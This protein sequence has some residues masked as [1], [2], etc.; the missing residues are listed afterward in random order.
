MSDTFRRADTFLLQQARLL[1][2]RLFAATW[3]GAPRAAVVAALAAYQ[4][5]DGGFGHALEPDTRCPLSLPIY[6]ET[7]LGA[8][9][10][11]PPADGRGDGGEAE[12]LGRACDY[13]DALATAVGADGAVP[14]ATPVIERFPRAAHWTEWTYEPAL[15]PTAG[16]VGRLYQL[17]IHHPWRDR[18]EAWCW[19]V[20]DADEVPLDAHTLREVYVFLEHVP[21]TE[22]ADAHAS[23]LAGRF[24]EAQMLHLDPAAT[25]YGLT[26]LHLAPSPDSR[27]RWLFTDEQLAGH[28]DRLAADQQAD[29]GWPITWEPPSEAAALEWRGIVTMEALRTLVDYGRVKPAT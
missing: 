5:D 7:A 24:S 25:G 19:R 15:N 26:P 17:G 2:R 29:G 16:L 3:L 1:E 27:W 11:L 18:A 21:D 22:R 12:M 9:T 6:V 13:L 28:L 10:S 14:A 23:A 20:L 8:L 4:N